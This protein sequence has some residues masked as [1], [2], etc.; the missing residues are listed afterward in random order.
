MEKL[1]AVDSL[2]ESIRLLEIRQ[3]EEGRIFKEQF[4]ETYESLKP[5]NIIKHTIRDLAHSVEVKNNLFETVLSLLSGYLAK[6]I[7]VDSKTSFLN[8]ILRTVAHF[9]ITNVITNNAEEIRLYFAN[10]INKFA[11]PKEKVS[12]TDGDS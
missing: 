8:R 6:K 12:E 10:L 2:K 5:S 1:S 4:K 3:A 9:G 11:T 7:M